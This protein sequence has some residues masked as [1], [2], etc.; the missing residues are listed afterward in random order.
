MAKHSNSKYVIF[1][2]AGNR[3][4]KWGSFES[5]E[6]AWDFILGDMTDALGLTD[7]DYQEYHVEALS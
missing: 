1:D 7:E 3:L 6:H 5:F 4:S 2:W